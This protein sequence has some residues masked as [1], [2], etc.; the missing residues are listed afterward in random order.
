MLGVLWSLD[1]LVFSLPL[2]LTVYWGVALLLLGAKWGSHRFDHVT[3]YGVHKKEPSTGIITRKHGFMM[4]YLVGAM[5]SL[6]CLCFHVLNIPPTNAFFFSNPWYLLVMYAFK[7]L[8][9]HVAESYV[10]KPHP[11]MAPQPFPMSLLL[12]LVHCLVRLW[13]TLA[14]H[15]WSLC[16]RVTAFN[17][18]SGCTFYMAAALT[19]AHVDLS[20]TVSPEPPHWAVLLGV[21]LLF[22][23]ASVRQVE[24]HMSL[25]AIRPHGMNLHSEERHYRVP[26][27]RAFEHMACPHYFFEIVVYGCIAALKTD[28]NAALLLLFVIANLLQRAR[29]TRTWYLETFGNSY[30]PAAAAL[31]TGPWHLAQLLLW[32]SG[33]YRTEVMPM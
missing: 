28:T 11:G 31:P 8:R 17:F 24:C 26:T 10:L 33:T 9:G 27:G 3:L 18:F 13:E 25:A 16:E 19:I 5:V 23:V 22:A 29:A 14:V 6:M 21:L 7:W 30:T 12:L 32:S 4:F 20:L 2:I 15:R 1:G